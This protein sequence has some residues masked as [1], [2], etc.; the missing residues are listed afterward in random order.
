MKRKH[1]SLLLACTLAFNFVPQVSTIAKAATD[2][3]VIFSNDFE[4]SNLP[5]EVG[6]ILTSE[7][8][9]IASVGGS[10]ALKISS[11]FDGSDDWDNN[12]HEIAF[13]TS[14]EDLAEGTKIEYDIIIP[15]S[16]ATF[17]GLMKSAG[18]FSTCDGDEWGW[19]SLDCGDIKSSDFK[20]LGNG[21]SSYHV[22]TPLT[23]EVKGV[24]KLNLQIDAY[25]CTYKGYM[26][27]DNVKISA[28]QKASQG[29]VVDKS[30]FYS[31]FE[32]GQKP[33]RVDG[34]LTSKDISI[35]TV[36][37]SNALKVDVKFDGTDD[38]DANKHELV[39]DKK[40]DDEISKDAKLEFDLLI[41][42]K[43]KNFDGLFKVAGGFCTF[44][45][46]DWGW[47]NNS[48][49][50]M[51]SSDF[52]DLGNGYSM[53]HVVV[54]PTDTVSGLQNIDIQ[55][56]SYMCDYVGEV[57]IDNLRFHEAKSSGETEAPTG[58]MWDFNDASK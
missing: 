58:L 48:G 24:R 31:D 14:S 51:K 9:S 45:G 33:S 13:N 18:G 43:N 56:E 29:S 23:E 50:E 10:K 34:V 32:A 3:K 25:N 54:H 36:N 47:V 53:K 7:D 42:T 57:Y 35:E 30:I 1:I 27:I 21:Y 37:D 46:D 4:S 6:G 12:K 22:S 19:A 41:P 40:Y 26:Y 16:N 15:T 28:P 2:E 49:A 11:K 8:V 52:E 55:L 17:S 38:W 44:D 20:S 5:D 39:F